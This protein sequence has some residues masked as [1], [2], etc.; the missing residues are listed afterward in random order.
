MVRKVCLV[1]VS[2]DNR[3]RSAASEAC[4]QSTG[5]KYSL[6]EVCRIKMGIWVLNKPIIH[7]SSSEVSCHQS[8]QV[9]NIVA[10]TQEENESLWEKL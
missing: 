2:G 1:E 10:K 8:L 6:T 3:E 7:L 9:I 5:A 4:M